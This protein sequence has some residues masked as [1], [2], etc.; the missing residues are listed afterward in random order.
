MSQEGAWE[1]HAAESGQRQDVESGDEET[2]ALGT[3]VATEAGAS[4][5]ARIEAGVSDETRASD[6]VKLSELCGWSTSRLVACLQ[7]AGPPTEV[8]NVVEAFAAFKQALS[9]AMLECLSGVGNSSA[10]HS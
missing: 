10:A 5:D 4:N 8:H 1:E 7:D 6:A 9:P 3:T 2:H